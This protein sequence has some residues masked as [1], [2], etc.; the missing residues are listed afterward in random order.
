MSD[1]EILAKAILELARKAARSWEYDGETCFS[2]G[3]ALDCESD[4][5]KILDNKQHTHRG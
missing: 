4:L 3:I 5:Q 1:N 2:E